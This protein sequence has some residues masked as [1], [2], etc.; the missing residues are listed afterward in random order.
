MVAVR[1]LT[2]WTH[3]EDSIVECDMSVC[4]TLNI[5]PTI[6]YLISPLRYMFRSTCV[7][8]R[9]IHSLIF[10][11]PTVFA[12]H[13][14]SNPTTFNRTCTG[15]VMSCASFYQLVPRAVML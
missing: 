12:N 4:A 9:P 8:L 11:I 13:D 6:V 15:I 2:M 3:T 14:G 10:R 1:W 5:T 7:R